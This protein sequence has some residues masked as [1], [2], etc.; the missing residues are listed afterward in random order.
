MIFAFNISWRISLPPSSS[1]AFDQ[2]IQPPSSPSISSN[3]VVLHLV[4]NDDVYFSF[5]WITSSMN[6]CISSGF[7]SFCNCDHASFT[8]C[9]AVL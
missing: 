6:F 9:G 4:R 2:D 1:A 5:V 3:L 8:S 7:F